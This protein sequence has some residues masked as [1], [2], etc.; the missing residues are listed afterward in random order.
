MT[1]RIALFCILLMCTASRAGE[2]QTPS[3]DN[4]IDLG[5]TAEER[6]ELLAEMRVMLASIQ[7]ILQGIGENDRERIAEAA[8]QSGNRMARATP[9]TLRAKLP[10]AFRDLGG[11]THMLFEELAVRAETDDMDSLAAATAV[12]MSQCLACHATFR[13]N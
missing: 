8:R 5:L 2:H 13:A 12:I 10:Q 7:G 6:T 3:L 9:E 11:P 1:K 4:R